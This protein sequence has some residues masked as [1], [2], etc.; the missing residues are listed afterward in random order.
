MISIVGA[1]VLSRVARVAEREEGE[2]EVIEVSGRVAN[3]VQ[4][5]APLF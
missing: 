3:Q 4:V 1:R 2:T 5:K